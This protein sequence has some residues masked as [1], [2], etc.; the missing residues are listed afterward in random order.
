MTEQELVKKL[1]QA[2]KDLERAKNALARA[3]VIW[4][5]AET[6]VIEAQ[7]ARDVAAETLRMQRLHQVIPGEEYELYDE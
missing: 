4:T 2:E 1:A 3:K 6:K 5:S 7:H